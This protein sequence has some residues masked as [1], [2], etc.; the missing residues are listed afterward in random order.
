MTLTVLRPG[1][2]ALLQDGGRR[3]HAADGVGRSGAADRASHARANLLVGNDPG[4][5]AIEVTLGGLVVR[6]ERD[7]TVAMTGAP[8]PA[9]IDGDPAEQ[10]TAVT[11]CQGQTLRLR[12]PKVGLR[13]YLAVA[14]GIDVP[15]VLGSASTDTL[16]KLGPAPLTKG[17]ELRLGTSS[18]TGELPAPTLMGE[19]VT[20]LRVAFGPRDDWFADATALTAGEWRVSPQSNRVGVRLDRPDPDQPE[21]T[22]TTD[23]EIPSEG[24]VLGAIQVPPSGQPVL[25]LADHPLT[26]GY[27]VVAVVLDDDIDRAAQLRPGQRLRFAPAS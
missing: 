3:G 6:G 24:I 17:D 27:P 14:G 18:G 15:L 13:S 19:P 10:D 9:D 25:F 5:V 12:A 22:R 16:S 11:L 23:A 4:A 26:G 7:L 2:L 8:A 21:L 20:T 1:P